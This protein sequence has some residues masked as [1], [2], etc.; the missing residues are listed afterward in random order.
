LIDRYSTVEGDVIQVVSWS[1]YQ[2]PQRPTPSKLP[3]IT[4]ATDVRTRA[5]VAEGSR[6]T[7]IRLA[8]HSSPEG[9]GEE[10]SGEERSGGLAHVNSSK[11]LA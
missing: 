9:S 7:P 11:T 4:E 1:E 5:H 10:R 8:E 2:H 3:P 6:I